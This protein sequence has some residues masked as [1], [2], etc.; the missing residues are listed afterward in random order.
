[1]YQRAYAKQGSARSRILDVRDVAVRARDDRR[2]GEGGVRRRD[3]RYAHSERRT[4]MS[5]SLRRVCCRRICESRLSWIQRDV[6]VGEDAFQVA[7]RPCNGWR[8]DIDHTPGG[9]RDRRDDEGLY[10]ITGWRVLC[11]TSVGAM[12]EGI[13][14]ITSEGVGELEEALICSDTSPSSDASSTSPGVDEGDERG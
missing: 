1:M 2:A 7:N 5:A 10:R 9:P 8:R 13:D 4:T 3:V 11:P 12:G 14:S 6:I